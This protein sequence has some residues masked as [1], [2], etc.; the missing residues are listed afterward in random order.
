VQRR[1][2]RHTS[3]PPCSPLTSAGD[4]IP[5]NPPA[6][7]GGFWRNS[8]AM[9]EPKNCGGNCG[10]PRWISAVSHG[11]APMPEIHRKPHEY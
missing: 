9:N 10:A 3:A 2:A 7:C 4:S 1:P 8:G 5:Q 11:N 6:R